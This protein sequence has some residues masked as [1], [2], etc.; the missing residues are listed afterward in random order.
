MDLRAIAL[1]N[2]MI[3]LLFEK[4]DALTAFIHNLHSEYTARFEECKNKLQVALES[5]TTALTDVHQRLEVLE[6]E[7]KSTESKRRRG[8][9]GG[10][11]KKGG[12]PSA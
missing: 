1:Q 12:V 11:G 9:R 2:G 10:R 4:N 8:C 5:T 7:L 6:A 3:R